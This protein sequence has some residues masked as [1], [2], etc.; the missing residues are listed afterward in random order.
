M[1]GVLPSAAPSFP[2]FVLSVDRILGAGV[3]S[4]L[5]C[6][7]S[8][9]D[10]KW[11]QPYSQTCG[12]V[13]IMV[14]NILMSS[15]HHCICGSQISKIQIIVVLHLQHQHGK[16]KYLNMNKKAK[17]RKSEVIQVKRFVSLISPHNIVGFTQRKSII[18]ERHQD[19]QF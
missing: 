6:I 2:P 12:F 16:I 10:A 13:N 5:K 8:F 17:F 19:R 1:S 14:D 4:T 9:L 3:Q 7:V 15:N 11:R 18:I